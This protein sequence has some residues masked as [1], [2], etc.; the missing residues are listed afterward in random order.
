MNALQAYMK[1]AEY[2]GRN[3]NDPSRVSIL[4]QSL[5]LDQAAINEA[6]K[7]VNQVRKDWEDAKVGALTPEQAA[8]MQRMQEAWVS[9]DQAISMVGRDLVVDVEPAFSA[10]AK[11]VSGWV[12]GNRRSCGFAWRHPDRDHCFHRAQARDVDLAAARARGRGSS[13]DR[14]CR[15]C[16]RWRLC[17]GA[18]RAER[19]RKEHL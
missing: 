14:T 8:A 18:E 6:L 5:G 12:E 19:R 1:F 9:L 4:G 2:A 17:I 3:R 11:A 7:G 15:R 16:R 10:I 13:C